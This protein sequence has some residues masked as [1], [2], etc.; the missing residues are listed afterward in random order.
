M[1]RKLSFAEMFKS[2]VFAAFLFL[3]NSTSGVAQIIADNPCP[4]PVVSE[5]PKPNGD[6]LPS[7]TEVG[8]ILKDL[9]LQNSLEILSG[10][11]DQLRKH[12]GSQLHTVDARLDC[13]KQMAETERLVS[14]GIKALVIEPLSSC[15]K[16]AV[17]IAKDHGV[18]I[19]A[20]GE[21][22]NLIGADAVFM[23]NPQTVKELVFG[24]PTQSANVLLMENSS[25]ASV[26]Q[27]DADEKLAAVMEFPKTM[28]ELAMISIGNKLTQGTT[29]PKTP[30]LDFFDTSAVLVSKDKIGNDQNWLSALD[31]KKYCL[32]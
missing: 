27:I 31:A 6:V 24:M 1:Q 14:L 22:A 9:R 32:D 29:P 18:F 7:G 15:P 8:V 4:Q 11:E 3:G 5:C 21:G 16:N 25:C 17:D 28:G 23:T 2:L 10:F 30:G 19:I 20:V 13:E 26:K 12:E